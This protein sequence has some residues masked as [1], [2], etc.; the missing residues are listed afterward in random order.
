MT[1]DNFDKLNL[2]ISRL[3]ALIFILSCQMESVNNEYSDD[4]NA[5][6]LK[7]LIHANDELKEISESEEIKK[8]P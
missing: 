4:V 3:N 2:N 1:S 8:E 6:M 7:T 5:L